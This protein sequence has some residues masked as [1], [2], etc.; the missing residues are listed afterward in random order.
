MTAPN[1]VTFEEV[2]I[3]A[4]NKIMAQ[5][6]EQILA[7]GNAFI[8]VGALHLSGDHGLV[9]KFRQAGFEVTQAGR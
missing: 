9:E 6:A 2:M 5:R 1:T 4:R 8:A 3:N 7:N